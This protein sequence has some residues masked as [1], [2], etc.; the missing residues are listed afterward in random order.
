MSGGLRHPFSGYLYTS[1]PDGRIRVED[2]ER[3]GYFHPDGRWIEGE[4]READPQFCG[5]VAGDRFA[6]RGLG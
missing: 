6:R 1:M 2:G 3:C 4:L 5:W